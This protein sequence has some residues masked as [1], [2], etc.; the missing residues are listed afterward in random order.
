MPLKSHQPIAVTSHPRSSKRS[1]V[2]SLRRIA[3]VL[4]T[5]LGV[6]VAIPSLVSAMTITFDDAGFVDGQIVTG[7]PGV[8]IVAD[9]FLLPFNNAVIFDSEQL[10]SRNPQLEARAEGLPRWSGGN[11]EGVQLNNILILQGCN[12][13][14]CHAKLGTGRQ[15]TGTIRFI[16]DV[17]ITSIGFDMINIDNPFAKFGSVTFTDMQNRSVTIPDKT[18]LASYQIGDNT[19]NR[20]D[21]FTAQ[22]LGL[23]PIRSVTFLMGGAGGLDNITFVPV[24]EPATGLFLGL[25]LAVLAGARRRA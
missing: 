19:A 5:A 8:R 20:I 6:L 2:S 4:I 12:D 10:G 25:G 23:G 3:T 18:L 17:P 1:S 16:F 21:P 7:V 13:A 22:G 15:P 9:N 14:A 11:L 24:P